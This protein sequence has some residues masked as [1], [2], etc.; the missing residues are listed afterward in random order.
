M[1]SYTIM[2]KLVVKIPVIQTTRVPAHPYSVKVDPL[3]DADPVTSIAGNNLIS[4]SSLTDW[5]S[6]SPE[7]YSTTGS[8]YKF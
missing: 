4:I 5:F 6:S 2:G 8:R 1:V 3:S 7:K